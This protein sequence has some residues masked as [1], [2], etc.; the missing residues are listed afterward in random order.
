MPLNFL[1][2]ATILGAKAVSDIKKAQDDKLH[3]ELREKLRKESEQKEK[4]LFAPIPDSL[5]ERY[6]EILQE[7]STNCE[8]PNAYMKGGTLWLCEKACSIEEVI[9]TARNHRVSYVD[10]QPRWRLARVSDFQKQSTRYRGASRAAYY[11]LLFH[12]N[13]KEVTIDN[14]TWDLF[15]ELVNRNTHAFG[16]AAYRGKYYLPDCICERF[17]E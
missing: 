14:E 5:L 11:I 17:D 1:F 15:T 16:L 2:G 3:D 4:D 9:E 12:R 13:S 8:I 10:P 7:C 6:Y